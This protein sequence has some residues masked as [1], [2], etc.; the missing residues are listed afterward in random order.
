MPETQCDTRKLVFD[1]DAE[2]GIAFG[3]LHDYGDA[4]IGTSGVFEEGAV[5]L[6]VV[7]HEQATGAECGPGRGELELHVLV[8]VQAVVQE[9]IDLA[10]LLEQGKK[11]ALRVAAVQRPATA[12]NGGDQDADIPVSLLCERR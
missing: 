1:G 4:D 2:E 10:K 9:E 5:A 7:G 8:G 11:Q 3:E 12:Q 6:D